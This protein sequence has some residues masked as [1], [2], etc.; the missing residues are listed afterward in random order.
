MLKKR[1]SLCAQVA[2]VA[3]CWLQ[4]ISVRFGFGKHTD[5][6]PPEDINYLL[7]LGF[8]SGFASILA[9]VWSK[10]SFAVTLLRITTGW[11]KRL[12]WFL[13]ITVNLILG[14]NATIQMGSCWPPERLWQPQIEGKCL[15]R[16]IMLRYN[17]FTACKAT[18]TNPLPQVL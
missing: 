2:L 14:A 16:Q 1:S 4:T 7:L 15:S 3:S 11:Y 12:V 13:I 10:T 6:I 5:D 9:A 8:S 18:H 17:I